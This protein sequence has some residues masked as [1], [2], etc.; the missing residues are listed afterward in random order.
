[1]LVP[2]DRLQ[3]LAGIAE[4]KTDE[5]IRVFN[6]AGSWAARMGQREDKYLHYVFRR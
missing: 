6:S 5:V 3:M 4:D 1:M 2:I